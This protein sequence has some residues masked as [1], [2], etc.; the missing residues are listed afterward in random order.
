VAIDVVVAGLGVRGAAWVR[1]VGAH[2]A[3]ELAACVDVDP[4]A[5]ERAGAE[6]EVP[7]ERR[8]TALDEALESGPCDALIV[9]TSADRHVEPC[10]LA[11][12]RG[13]GLLVE[14]PFT[15]RLGEAVELVELAEQ[16][17]APVVVGQN[18]RYM[19]GRQAARRV[20]SE[21]ALGRVAMAVAH[22]YHGSD[23]LPPHQAEM[24]QS[25]LWGPVVHHI[26]S[27]SYV[28]GKR[29]TGV[30]AD[31]FTTPGGS[32]PEGASIHALLALEDD[33]RAMYSATYE[34]KG[35]EFFERG[36]EYYERLIGERAT[37][38]MFHRWLV[39]CE[40][41]K[42]PRV[43]RRG[44]RPVTE[45]SRLLTQL[46]RALLDGEEPDSSGHGNLETVAAME[47]CI[48]SARQGCWVNP[49]ELLA[50][51]RTGRNAV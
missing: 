36:Q 17:G 25:I 22:Y 3:F 43:I 40:R 48:H 30:M 38:H 8:F 7:T 35:H 46:Q 51:S 14:K 2:P 21:G 28:L 31:T 47:A 1:E 50:E 45:E 15:T 34:S 24:P 44:S 11:L 6:L 49:Q 18:Y 5:L 23:H 42:R 12:S 39:L 10:R 27:L 9:A 19:R 16:A 41:G 20:V 32:L 26:D 4:E 13:L 33:V 29:I 37:L